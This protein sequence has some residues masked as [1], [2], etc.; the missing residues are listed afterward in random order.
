[1]MSARDRFEGLAAEWSATGRP[2]SLLPCGQ[3]L[4]ALRC[5]SHSRG[6][7]TDGMSDDLRAFMEASERAQP[8]GWFDDCL[9]ERASCDRCGETFR[10]ENLMV[11]THCSRTRCYR[12]ASDTERLANGN[13]GCGCGGELV[14]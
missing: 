5:W 12:C 4:L 14:G 6:G 1:M 13:L 2:A 3:R 9:S 11:C 10:M 7:K 8:E